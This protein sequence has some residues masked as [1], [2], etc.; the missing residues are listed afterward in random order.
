MAIAG[1]TPL[2][3]RQTKSVGRPPDGVE[4]TL[5]CNVAAVRLSCWLVLAGLVTGDL[6]PPY[7]YYSN[8]TDYGYS[9]HPGH[10]KRVFGGDV[11]NS[12]SESCIFYMIY[13]AFR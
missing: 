6:V 11:D 7:S 10:T 1:E 4:V 3:T 13:N 12:Y 2:D 8:Y 9:E 5:L